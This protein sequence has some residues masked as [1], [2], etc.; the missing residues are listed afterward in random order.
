MYSLPWKI[1]LV[2]VLETLRVQEMLKRPGVTKTFISHGFYTL[3]GSGE[4]DEVSLTA[5][6]T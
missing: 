5:S 2:V 3:I 6:S 1:T 4:D